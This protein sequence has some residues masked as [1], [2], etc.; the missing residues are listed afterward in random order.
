MKVKAPGVSIPIC[1][2]MQVYSAVNDSP[3]P[4]HADAVVVSIEAEQIV[5][6]GQSGEMEGREWVCAV[7]DIMPIACPG[8]LDAKANSEP[9]ASMTAWYTRTELQ[10]IMAN[11]TRLAIDAWAR[12]EIADGWDEAKH[13]PMLAMFGELEWRLRVDA[14]Y[15]DNGDLIDRAEADG[16]FAYDEVAAKVHPLLGWVRGVDSVTMHVLNGHWAS[17][18]SE[19]FHE[20]AKSLRRAIADR[21]AADMA[22]QGRVRAKSKQ[23]RS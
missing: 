15:C 2:G 22:A 20:S 23:A 10:A 3:F 1:T 13:A 11:F 16:V 14:W 7:G 17:S 6:R 4:F 12:V 19:R 8:E 21:A 9:G 18:D 5:V